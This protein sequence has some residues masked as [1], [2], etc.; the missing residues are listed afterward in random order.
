M[1]SRGWFLQD[2]LQEK[3]M[4]F[5]ELADYIRA[6]KQSGVETIA[7][8]VQFYRKFSVPLFALIMAITSIPFAFLAGNRGAMAGWG[9][10]SELPSRI[11]PQHLAHVVRR[12]IAAAAVLQARALDAAGRPRQP[13]ADRVAIAL[14]ALQFHSQPVIPLPGVVSQAAAAARHCCRPARR[15]ARRC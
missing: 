4:N 12:K 1:R 5:E 6:L 8:Q 2:A 3:H 14:R 11:G 10:V 15:C 13:R 7:L 9:S